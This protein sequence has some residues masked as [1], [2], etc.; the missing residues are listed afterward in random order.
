MDELESQL[1]E[2]QIAKQKN[3]WKI[4]GRDTKA[5]KALFSLYKSHEAPKINYP[6]PKPKSK[7]EVDR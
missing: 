3:L 1:T 6:K 4:F 5:G 2:E 7:E